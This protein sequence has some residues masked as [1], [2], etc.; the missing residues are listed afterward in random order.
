VSKKFRVTMDMDFSQLAPDALCADGSQ[1]ENIRN[2][3]K[4]MVL[5]NARAQA[6][7]ELHRIRMEPA[8]SADVKTIRMSEQ[9]RAMMTTLMAEA[10]LSVVPLSDATPIQTELPFERQYAA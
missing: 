5:N 3:F 1:V 7:D 10:N 8:M 2:A 6:K 9:L 4:A